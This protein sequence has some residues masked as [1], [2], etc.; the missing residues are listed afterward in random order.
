MWGPLLSASASGSVHFERP[1]IRLTTSSAKLSS[2]LSR[3]SLKTGIRC[4]PAQLKSGR[5]M[6]VAATT[7]GWEDGAPAEGG[8]AAS[9]AVGTCAPD[10]N[11]A[12]QTAVRIMSPLLGQ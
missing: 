10:S 11:T 1:V 2:G 3:P 12:R 7:D 8:S 4:Q 9:T 5:A 6:R